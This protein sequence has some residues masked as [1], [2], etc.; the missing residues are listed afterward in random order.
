M[1]FVKVCGISRLEDAELAVEL[2]AAALGFIFAPSPRRVTPADAR[3][4]LAGIGER[5][6]VLGPV[7]VFVDAHLSPEWPRAEPF[8][9]AI[10]A[11]GSESPQF[12]DGIPRL[13]RI[14]VFRIARASDLDGIGAYAASADYFMFDTKANGKAGGTGQTF[15]WGVLEGRTFPRPVILAGG[16]TPENVGEAIRRV[17]PFAV[18]GASGTEESPGKKDPVKLREFFAAVR[19]ADG[20]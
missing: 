3:A 4:L 8:L 7:G 5:E 11:H 16:L 14:K 17:K 10:Q 2:G 1:T 13:T 18:D 12:L 19:E 20:A 9:R 15:D 6:M